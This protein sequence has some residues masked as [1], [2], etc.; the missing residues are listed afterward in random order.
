[1]RVKMHFNVKK[2]VLLKAFLYLCSANKNNKLKIWIVI[3]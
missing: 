1:M 2:I 3:Q